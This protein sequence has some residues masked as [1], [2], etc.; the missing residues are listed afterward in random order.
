MGDFE[1][2][3]PLYRKVNTR[4]RGVH[5]RKG[6]DYR[7]ERNSKRE[8]SNE[9]DEVS[10]GPMHGA[11][12]RGRDYTPLF[13]FLLSRVG[14]DW[15]NVHKEAVER[16]DTA[17]PIYWMVAR[18]DHEKTPTMRTENAFFSGL[19]V[20]E[21]GKLAKVAPD[22]RN[23]DLMPQCACCTHTFNGVALVQKYKPET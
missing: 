16:L 20:D 8:R 23:E 19:Y 13:R 7:H 17:E 18:N 11:K 9:A 12:R 21:A 10:R 5:H 3:K 4:A 22:L 6:G 14:E 15:E 2:A 1:R